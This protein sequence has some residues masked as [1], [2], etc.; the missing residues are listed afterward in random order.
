MSKRDIVSEM[1]QSD[2]TVHVVPSNQ[3]EPLIAAGLVRR[4]TIDP[5]PPRG[6][7]AVNLTA[8]GRGYVPGQ[9]I[10]PVVEQPIVPADPTTESSPD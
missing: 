7:V 10:E 9:A 6:K 8:R 1:Q 2:Q 5:A 3:G 4:A